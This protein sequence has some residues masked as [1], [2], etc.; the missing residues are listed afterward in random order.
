VVAVMSVV[1]PIV[2]VLWWLS[3][4]VDPEPL[5]G[6]APPVLPVGLTVAGEDAGCGSSSCCPSDSGSPRLQA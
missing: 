6:D 3:G 4:G 2:W 1:V 5:T